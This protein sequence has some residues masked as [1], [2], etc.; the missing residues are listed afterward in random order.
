MQIVAKLK[1]HG[2]AVRAMDLLEHQTV[3]LLAQRAAD[4]ASPAPP[5]A[6]TTARAKSRART[7]GRTTRRSR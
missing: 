2:I 7:T 4:A 6:R 1:E 3:R 5:T